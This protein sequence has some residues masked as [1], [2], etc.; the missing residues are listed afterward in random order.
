MFPVAIIA[1]HYNVCLNLL[2][3]LNRVFQFRSSIQNQPIRSIVNRRLKYF[4][5]Q[6]ERDPK[7]LELNP[8]RPSGNFPKP[9]PPKRDYY[10]WYEDEKTGQ[11]L[12]KF[13]NPR[14]AKSTPLLLCSRFY[15]ID[16]FFKIFQSNIILEEKGRAS[17]QKK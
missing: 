7:K 6:L 3:R 4:T 17:R 14:S 5:Y 15:I 12:T 11:L 9:L 8:N 16:N 1:S 10:F 13:V 2:K